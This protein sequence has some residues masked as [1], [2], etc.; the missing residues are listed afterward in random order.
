VCPNTVGTAVGASLQFRFSPEWRTEASV[1]TVGQCS[2]S[3]NTLQRQV[4]ADLFWERR[5]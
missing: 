4:G 5:Y 2:S 1:E 3:V